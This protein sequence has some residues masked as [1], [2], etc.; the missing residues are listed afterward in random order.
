M[1]A[2]ANCTQVGEEEKRRVQQE[3]SSSLW[4]RVSFSFLLCSIG[5]SIPEDPEVL[6][7]ENLVEEKHHQ[8]MRSKRRGA[9]GRDV[10][11]NPDTR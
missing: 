3:E 1:S 9:L 5:E 10:K 7:T 8:Q 4:Y 2:G 6:A 11:P